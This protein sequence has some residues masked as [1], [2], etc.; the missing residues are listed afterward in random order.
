MT[1]RSLAA[2]IFLN[3]ALLVA[4][5]VTVFTPPAQ[6]QLGGAARQFLMIAGSAPAGDQSAVYILDVQSGAI[7]P[8]FFNSANNRFEAFRGR[9]IS[10]DI[11]M[12]GGGR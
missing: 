12:A 5:A 2:L 4:L 9:V 6:A 11:G 10:D 1:H 3:V 7:A 8:I